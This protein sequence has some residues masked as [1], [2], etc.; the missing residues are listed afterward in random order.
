MYES[1]P[2]LS[3]SLTP[4]LTRGGLS[5]E[6]S[7]AA[8]EA[9]LSSLGRRPVVWFLWQESFLPC[10]STF[11]IYNLLPHQRQH[12]PA[13][14]IPHPAPRIPFFILAALPH[15]YAPHHPDSPDHPEM[16]PDIPETKVYFYYGF[17]P[18]IVF[19]IKTPRIAG[20]FVIFPEIIS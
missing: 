2:L 19:Y 11:P 3:A 20:L 14:R 10:L 1:T 15:F 18:H 8:G 6:P 7:R 4:P 12:L 9:G 17:F 5:P 16:N 13:S